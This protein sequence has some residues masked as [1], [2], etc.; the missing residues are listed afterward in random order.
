M[1]SV[2]NDEIVLPIKMVVYARSGY[3]KTYMIFKKLKEWISSGIIDP[4]RL[5]LFSK[6]FKSDKEQQGLIKYIKSL[7]YKDFEKK[8]CADEIKMDFIDMVFAV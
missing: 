8:N 4:S 1:E 3:G 5:V 2:N 6:T 7:G